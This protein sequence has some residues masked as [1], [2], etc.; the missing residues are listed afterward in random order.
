MY[1]KF[2]NIEYS[3]RVCNMTLQRHNRVGIRNA[4][5]LT[6]RPFC[7]ANLSCITPPCDLVAGAWTIA[8]IQL[9][10]FN[11]VTPLRAFNGS[12]ELTSF[13]DSEKSNFF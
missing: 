7:V 10:E 11:L 2:G 5:E 6:N 1:F 4:G 3:K 8:D 12:K 13:N 9:L